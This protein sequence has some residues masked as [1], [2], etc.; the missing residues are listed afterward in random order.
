MAMLTRLTRTTRLRAAMTLALAYA[1]CVLAPQVALA[2]MD[3]AAV[4]HCLTTRHEHRTADVPTH[5]VDAHA[6]HA[7]HDQG[8]G[9]APQHDGHRGSGKAQTDGQAAGANCCGIF[10]LSAMPMSPAPDVTPTARITSLVSAIDHGIAGRGPDRIDR[11]PIVLL[12]H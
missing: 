12:P 4:V 10:C 1:L 11:P 5:N 8:D 9:A 7:A 2:F 3:G 6:H